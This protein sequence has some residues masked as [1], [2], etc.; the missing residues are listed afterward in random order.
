MLRFPACP[1]ARTSGRERNARKR[2]SI[3]PPTC[4]S[5]RDPP[6]VNAV[7]RVEAVAQQRDPARQPA[8]PAIA[9]FDQREP[10]IGRLQGQARQ[11]ARHSP[12]GGERDEAGR[13]GNRVVA[14]SRWKR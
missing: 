12:V 9:G 11:H 4:S 5:S 13:M 1:F 2:R 10:E 7:D 8:E 3:P 6:G 14:A